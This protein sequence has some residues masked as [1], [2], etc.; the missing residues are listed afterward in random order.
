MQTSCGPLSWTTGLGGV[1]YGIGAEVPGILP[2]LNIA[3]PMAVTIGNSSGSKNSTSSEKP[4]DVWL[5]KTP[6]LTGS[7]LTNVAGEP[8]GSSPGYRETTSSRHSPNA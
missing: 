5:R 3:V 8:N 1:V 6:Q 7:A 2:R 4:G